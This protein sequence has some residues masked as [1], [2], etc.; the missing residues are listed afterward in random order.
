MSARQRRV[1]AV[2]GTRPEQIKL[3]PVVAALEVRGFAVDTLHTGQSKDLASGSATMRLRSDVWSGGLAHGAAITMQEV[4]RRI[5]GL[6][7]AVLVQ[8]DTASAFAGATAAFLANVPVGH[9]EAGLRTYASEPHPEEALRRA[10]APF[11]RWHF[12]PDED[13]ARNLKN[14]GVADW[15]VQ[16]VGNTVIDTLPPMR[17]RVLATL[18]RREN[19]GAR[20]SAAIARLREFSAHEGVEVTLVRHPNWAVHQNEL[21][22][23]T[24]SF[25]YV[26]PLAR[27]EL[28]AE[29]A[30]ASL[31]VTDSGGL[32]EEAAHFGVPALVLRT[33]TERTALERLGAV[34]LVDPD[35]HLKLKFHLMKH[36]Y[37]RTAYGRGDAAEKI[38]TILDNELA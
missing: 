34:Q 4:T 8:G 37:R 19:W 33:S 3:A 20:I 6:Y 24:E 30:S 31:L 16:V 32:Q 5:E 12:A 28:L 29:L 15:H 9:V 27:E 23:E 10:I 1:L 25:R 38:A 18:H 21:P 35:S 17:L 13:A 14:E 11:A 7:D 22:D 36:L 2:Y 26:P